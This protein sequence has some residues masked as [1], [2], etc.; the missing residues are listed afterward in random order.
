MPSET[1]SAFPLLRVAALATAL[2]IFPPPADAS[3]GM[4]NPPRPAAPPPTAAAPAA[5]S[6]E[7]SLECALWALVEALVGAWLPVTAAPP[8]CLP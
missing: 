1:L 6:A 4:G 2:S 3:W 5:A 8:E 7:A